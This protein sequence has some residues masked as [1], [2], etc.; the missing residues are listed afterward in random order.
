ME[1]IRINYEALLS[2][3]YTWYFDAIIGNFPELSC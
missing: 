2:K 3:S 1:I